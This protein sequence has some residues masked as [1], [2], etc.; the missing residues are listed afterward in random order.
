M[1]QHLT[2]EQLLDYLSDYIDNNL[3]EEL[4][5]AAQEHLATCDN[6]RV[7]L[8]STQQM[9]LLYREKGKQQVIPASRQQSLYDQ[10]KSAFEDRD[11]KP[12][13]M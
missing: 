4:A 1:T 12:D 10:L 7:V 9:I 3:S 6:C 11:K 2:C 8:D 13:S 5:L